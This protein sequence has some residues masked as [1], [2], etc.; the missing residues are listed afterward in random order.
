M[1]VWGPDWKAC[2][3]HSPVAP[4]HP[5]SGLGPPEGPLTGTTH[6]LFVANQIGFQPLLPKAP[7]AV[8]CGAEVVPSLEAPWGGERELGGQAG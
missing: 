2:S 4:G 8:Q 3:S 7:R 5:A 6:P 1:G